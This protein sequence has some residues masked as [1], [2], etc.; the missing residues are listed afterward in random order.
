LHEQTHEHVPEMQKQKQKHVQQQRQI[1]AILVLAILV[2]AMVVLVHVLS[3]G[4]VTNIGACSDNTGFVS[5]TA[6]S[7]V[8]TRSGI[9]ATIAGSVTF[10]SDTAV[11][12]EASAIAAAIDSG[13]DTNTAH[14]WHQFLVL[15]Q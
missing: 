7:A 15:I 8:T 5:D 4:S 6:A 13:S 14:E 11:A 10:D 1:L 2:L 3:V 12:I 9:A